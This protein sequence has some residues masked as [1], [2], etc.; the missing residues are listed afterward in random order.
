MW[1]RD[2]LKT[3]ASFRGALSKQT[4]DEVLEL[5]PGCPSSN[6]VEAF[7]LVLMVLISLSVLVS[8]WWR[9]ASG[10]LGVAA[11]LPVSDAMGYYRCAVSIAGLE[12]LVAPGSNGE[13]CSRRALYPGMLASLLR[14]SGWQ[15][16]LALTFQ[17]ALIGL[18]IG[19]FVL[20]VQRV[21]GWIAGLVSVVGLF[22]A[23]REFALGTFMTEALGLPAG[24]TGIALLILSVRHDRL[25]RSLLFAGL[26]LVSLGM[27]IRAGALLALPF[28]GLW[29]FLATRHMHWRPRTTVL[30]CSAAMLA[31]GMVLQF[32]LVRS[33]GMEASN[34]GGNF[35]ATLYGLSTGSRDWSEAYRDFADM[36]RTNPSEGQV[37]AHVQ[38]VA[39]A[40]I[41]AHPEVFLR[42]LYLGG[43]GF[44]R[45]PFTIGSMTRV[46]GSLA[47]LIVIGLTVCVWHFRRPV[48]G[49]LLA[50]AAGE[51]LSAPLI[52]DTGGHRGFFVT[53][54]AR[55]ALAG[56][57]AAWLIETVG[58][59]FPWHWKEA[60]IRS[61]ANSDRRLR[62]VA[63]GLALALLA[64]AMLPL[65]P[66][67]GKFRLEQAAAQIL[68]EP[69]ES[70]VVAHLGRESLVLIFGG[71]ELPL[72]NDGITIGVGKLERDPV[73]KRS[74][75]LADLKP[76]P[77]GT[78]LVYAVQRSGKDAGLVYP[79]YSRSP[80]PD[81]EGRLISL[82]LAPATS[83][84]VKLGDFDFLPITRWHVH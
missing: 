19:V 22:I 65:T 73:A 10:H 41:R 68:C 76:Q 6:R 54:G 8:L 84:E 42:S 49:L 7:V 70:Q 35:A 25:S 59:F 36:F 63:S 51:L 3:A 45:A 16:A 23:A 29:V 37:F 4:F 77:A 56:V 38:N 58:R 39:I 1:R 27:A 31:I 21:F 72:L 14:L 74:W 34:T 28:L 5:K 44:I 13:W 69:G 43:E 20:A 60:T 46:N 53:I 2:H 17:A 32:L 83:S 62:Y 50:F 30:A 40:N 12:T 75:W 52:F 47:A 48:F 24:L 66:S 26:A 71:R 11:Y 82:C 79:A 55:L 57:G 33:L 78:T 15:P 9:G 67:L 64:L 80:L 61:G 81:A 18:A